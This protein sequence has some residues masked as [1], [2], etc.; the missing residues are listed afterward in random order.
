[1]DIIKIKH[2]MRMYAV[3]IILLGAAFTRLS[4]IENLR[5]I[6]IVTLLACGVAIGMLISSIKLYFS[7]KKNNP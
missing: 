1:M 6:H 5:A 4:G 7:L 2:S 3:V